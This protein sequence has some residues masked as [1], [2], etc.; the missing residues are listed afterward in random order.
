MIVT[1]VS[2]VLGVANNGT[3]IA[4]MHL[5]S[6]LSKKGYQVRILCPDADKKGVDN[7]FVVDTM[8]FG[9]FNRIVEANGV[10]LAKGDTMTIARAL[11]NSDEVHI[12]MPFA[13]GRKTVKIA[14]RLGLPV[15]AGFHVQ[16]ENVTSHFFNFMTCGWI[17]HLV[18]KNFYH[19]FYRYVDSIH[20]PTAFIRDTFE[21]AIKRKTPSY[22]ISNGV[23]SDF[24]PMAVGRDPILK[25]KFVIICTGR[26]SKEKKQ[27][28][29]IK[30]WS[31]SKYKDKIQVIFAGEGPRYNEMKREA[32]RDGVS[33]LYRFYDRQGL[34]KALNSADLYVHTSEI[35]IE[36]ISCL[37]AIST[38][39]VPVINNSPKSATVAFALGEHNLFKK[40]DYRS[41]TNQIE[42]WIE[43][44]E[45]KKECAKKYSTYVGQFNFDV[46]M[47]KMEAM[48]LDTIKKNKEKTKVE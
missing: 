22:V 45:K 20:Y 18:Y 26:F 9:P 31:K 29:L 7:Y 1:I 42:Y 35:E 19:G 44:P 10:T 41:L 43:H 27:R 32:K 16:A 2:D 46:C 38:G 34:V 33:P 11:K 6:T 13:L 40:N 30:A 21:K 14:K 12:M 25:D 24:K 5:A 48:I 23:S 37:E 4:A 8:N 28:L 39:L 47:D 15:S 36:A 3:T 17:N